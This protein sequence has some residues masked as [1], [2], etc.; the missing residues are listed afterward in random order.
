MTTQPILDNGHLRLTFEAEAGLVSGFTLDV[1]D[2]GQPHRMAATR[3]ISRAIYRDKA[4]NR[5]ELV[6]AACTATVG[7]DRLELRQTQTDGDGVAATLIAT[8]ALTDDPSQ[9]VVDYRLE[10]SESRGLLL[11]VGP[12]LLAGE[13]SF[14]AAKDEALFP[15]LEYL[16][17]DEPSSDTRFAAEKYARRHLPHPYKITIPLMAVSHDGRT[18]GL[19]WDPNQDWRAAW[20]HPAAVFSSPNRLQEGARNHWLALAAPS[21]DPRWRNEGELEAHAPATGKVATL[22]ARLVV[23]PTG[24]VM[25]IVRAWVE[26]YGLPEP[27]DAGH[28]YWQN[29]ELCVHS[30]LD[31]AWDE[32]AEGWHHTLSDPWGPRYEANLANLLWRYGRWTEGD[33][34]LQARGRDQVRRAVARARQ[35]ERSA[36]PHLDLALVFGHAAVALDATA[37][38]C[39]AAMAEQQADGS[40]PWQPEAVASGEFKTVDRLALMGQ[41]KDSA[42]G[43]TA[44]HVRPILQYALSTGDAEAVAAARRAADWCNAQRRPEGAQTWELHLHVPD[45]LAVPYL[46]NLNLGVYELT[47]DIAY[48]EA[49]NRWA[50]TGLPFTYLWN[51]YYRPIMRYGTIPVFGVTFHDVQ[52][53]FGV[54]VQWNGLVYAEALLRLA[55][56][57]ASDGPADWRRLAEGIARHGMQEQMTCGPHLGMYPDA[58]SPVKADEEYT[59]WL[60]P[61]LVGINTF[62]L[63]GLPV[64]PETR[65]L[66][67]RGAAAHITSGATVLDASRD[68]SGVLRLMLQDQPG[69]TSFTL[70][71]LLAPPAEIAC[72]GRPL[73]VV[74]DLD[75]AAEGWQWLESHKVA[76]VKVRYERGIVTLQVHDR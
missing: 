47:G 68:A 59:W 16:L 57:R 49:A 17:D 73:P 48:L 8:F 34:V 69:E 30:F 55:R 3:P 46:I 39:R 42:T 31:V 12:S 52:S 70:L 62:P 53:W 61:Q 72:E 60:N 29:V 25:G 64:I 27:P 19:M 54:I 23:R 22:S 11:W 4:G 50:W 75:A 63:A 74:A 28:D 56:Y 40:W 20:R 26:T 1:Y 2:N 38:A 10:T 9:V 44:S 41:E 51:G 13:G 76:L 43:F 71:A 14:G 6:F 58:F 67:E 37:A 32:A 24:G 45:V 15:G 35:K 65:I 66:R 7:D 36:A 18:V 21:A 5:Q 33:P